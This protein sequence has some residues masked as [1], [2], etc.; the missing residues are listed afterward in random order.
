[1]LPMLAQ[2]FLDRFFPAAQFTMPNPECSQ[3]WPRLSLMATK[4]APNSNLD[5]SK[6][7]PRVLPIQTWCPYYK[8]TAKKP[9]VNIEIR[10]SYTNND[11]KRLKSSNHS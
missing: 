2:K 9:L 5:Q 1:M 11:Q 8:W 6:F 7:Q 10:H 3:C 4:N